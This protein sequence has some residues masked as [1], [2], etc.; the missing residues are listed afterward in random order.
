MYEVGENT[1]QLHKFS[2]SQIIAGDVCTT[3]FSGVK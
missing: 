2:T 3:F 1:I